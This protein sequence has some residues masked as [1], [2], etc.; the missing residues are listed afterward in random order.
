MNLKTENSVSMTDLITKNTSLIA[1]FFKLLFWLT[2]FYFIFIF[3]SS[4]FQQIVVYEIFFLWMMEKIENTNERHIFLLFRQKSIQMAKNV[5]VKIGL[6]TIALLVTGISY[7]NMTLTF[8]LSMNIATYWSLYCVQIDR[9]KQNKH[10][11]IKTIVTKMYSKDKRKYTNRERD[12]L[13]W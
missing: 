8:A 11:I 7:R 12:E 1:I 6:V 10:M 9:K 3:F 5:D 13:K 4:K 2:L